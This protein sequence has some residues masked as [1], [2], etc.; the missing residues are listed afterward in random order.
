MQR[1]AS[2]AA[3]CILTAF[4]NPGRPV[5]ALAFPELTTIARMPASEHRSRHSS[6]GADCVPE[7]VKRA[8]L[9]V[10]GALETIRPR[11]SPP[12]GLIPQATPAAV[13]PFGNPPP[14][15]ETLPGTSTQRDPKNDPVA[16]T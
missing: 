3:P 14:G 2:A 1:L 9:V 8:A 10:A 6:T 13:N 4:S 7:L 12:L 16:V 5:A 15:S 11:S